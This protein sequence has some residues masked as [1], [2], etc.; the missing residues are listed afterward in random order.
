MGWQFT[1]D[2]DDEEQKSYQESP[3]TFEQSW[4]MEIPNKEET[5]KEEGGLVKES[6]ESRFNN[7][8][9]S[10]FNSFISKLNWK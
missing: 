4:G 6:A 9:V 7:V 10:D 3:S 8:K 5:I 2:T 1:R